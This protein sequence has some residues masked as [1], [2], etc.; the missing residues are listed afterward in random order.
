M[1]SLRTKKIEYAIRDIEV[2][3]KPGTIKVNIGDPLAYDFKLPKIM[4]RELIKAVK[5]GY[6][7][8]S[9]SQ[10]IYELRKKI[11]EKEEVSPDDVIV[12][13]GT[14]EAI[15]FIFAS[16]LNKGDKVL[17]PTPCYPQYPSM[18]SLWDGNPIFY[19]CDENWLPD[20]SEIRKKIK[21]V[22]ALVLI[23]P[24]NPTGGVYPKDIIEEICKICEKNRVLIISDEIYSDLTYEE[25]FFSVQEFSESETII[26]NGV[27]KCYLAPGWRIGWMTFHNFKDNKLKE[28]ILKLC[29][30]RL[31]ANTPAQYA[32]SKVIDEGI[33][34][35]KKYLEKVKEKLRKRRDFM[36]KKFDEYNIN[37]VLPKGA[38]YA[39]PWI[40]NKKWKDDLDFVL[41][42]RDK[43][44]VLVVHGSGFFYKSR[45]I[46]FRIVFLPNEKILGEAIDRI[47]KFIK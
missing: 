37:C 2:G 5:T 15:N 47:G 44:K 29:R 31:C 24:N 30:L 28:S 9:D 7:F 41:K 38:F 17:L 23:N 43:M 22:K 8:Y 21:N 40:E 10:G 3:V 13:S 27:S 11:A 46:Y 36:M 14:S 6:N 35:E 18:V 19:K 32:V 45:D 34:N 26:L 16:I 25:K 42:L 33:N 12:T 1:I 39:F 20:L 4:E